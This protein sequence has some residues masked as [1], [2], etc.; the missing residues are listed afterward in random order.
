[1]VRSRPAAVP[2]TSV[3]APSARRDHHLREAVGAGDEVAVG[4]GGQQRHVADV[5]VGQDDAEL[6]GIG[7][8]VG[9][10]RHA[11]VVVGRA[12]HAVGLACCSSLPVE[13]SLPSTPTMYSRRNTWCDGMRGVGL[14]LVDERRRRVDVLVDV[15]RR[16]EDAVGAGQTARWSRASAP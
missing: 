12:E 2:S 16:A 13:C 8:D 6:Q 14:V 4:V 10:G 11:G 15:V 1:M 5:V 3:V 9:P 7:L